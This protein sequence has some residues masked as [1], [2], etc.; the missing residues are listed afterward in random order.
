MVG[1]GLEMAACAHDDE[2]NNVESHYHCSR[3]ADSFLEECKR[4]ILKH[5]LGVHITVSINQPDITTG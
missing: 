3:P 5:A 1:L 2:Q 4:A